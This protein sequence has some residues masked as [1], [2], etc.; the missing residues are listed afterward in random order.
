MAATKSDLIIKGK[1][2]G[3]RRTDWESDLVFIVSI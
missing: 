2:Q 1:L 3:N